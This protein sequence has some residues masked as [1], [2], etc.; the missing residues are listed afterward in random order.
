M[1]S[2]ILERDIRIV[3]ELA[4]L[5]NIQFSIKNEDGSKMTECIVFVEKAFGVWK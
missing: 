5:M 4:G 2:A 1:N 3:D